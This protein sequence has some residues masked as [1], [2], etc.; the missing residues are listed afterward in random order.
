MF[1]ISLHISLT[2]IRLIKVKNW[3]GKQIRD[4]MSNQF[5]KCNRKFVFNPRVAGWFTT[6]YCW[7]IYR[8]WTASSKESS[9]QHMTMS[10]EVAASS[11]LTS[12]RCC[13]S[14]AYTAVNP[15]K[16]C[17]RINQAGVPKKVQTRDRRRRLLNVCKGVRFH[18]FMLWHWLITTCLTADLFWLQ[19]LIP[20]YSLWP[21]FVGGFLHSAVAAETPA[22]S[23]GP[24]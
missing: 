6:P 19:L 10:S 4:Q 9:G 17:S 3:A 1:Y 20:W 22:C 15:A 14:L 13:S 11:S 2:C 8:N 16:T 7:E 24:G 18:V 12:D 5:F 21:S 23:L